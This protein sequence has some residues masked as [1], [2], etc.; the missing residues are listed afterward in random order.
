[1]RLEASR[2]VRL[3]TRYEF[4]SRS[5]A[6]VF[7]VNVGRVPTESDCGRVNDVYEQWETFGD[8]FHGSYSSRRSSS[9]RLYAIKSSSIDPFSDAV[10]NRPENLIGAIAPTDSEM[11]GTTEAPLVRWLSQPVNAGRRHGRTYAVGLTRNETDINDA[12]RLTSDAR[13]QLARIFTSLP[14]MFLSEAGF[15]MVRLVYTEHGM[16]VRPNPQVDIIAASMDALLCGNQRR[17]SKPLTP[18]STP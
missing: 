12:W 8:G 1:M 3:E 14:A 16:P 18:T 15:T 2:V 4:R 5:A 6:M 11:L 7:S 13:M 10:Q 9:S 17:R